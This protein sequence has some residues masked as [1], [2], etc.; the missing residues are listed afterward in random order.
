MRPLPSAKGC[1][2]G[3]RAGSSEPATADRLLSRR[4]RRDTDRDG[5]AAAVA[6]ACDHTDDAQV[7]AADFTQT[8]HLDRWDGDGVRVVFGCDARA[9]LIGEADAY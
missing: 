3:S 6:I 9:N 4:E 2:H 7:R 8:R 1:M 5:S